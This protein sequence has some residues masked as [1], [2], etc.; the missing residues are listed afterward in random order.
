MTWEFN[1]HSS[2]QYDLNYISKDN[3]RF[4]NLDPDFKNC[5]ST[6]TY[7]KIGDLL[8]WDKLKYAISFRH[9]NT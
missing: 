3:L 5:I 2:V 8:F 9:K 6:H 7:L 1:V 4:D